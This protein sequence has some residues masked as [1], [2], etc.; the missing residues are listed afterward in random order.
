MFEED[1]RIGIAHRSREQTNHIERSRRRNYLQPGYHHAPVLDALAVLRAETC[2]A[3]IRGAYNQRTLHLA[4]RHVAALGK[5]IRE[6]IETDGN[7]VR[8]H[9]LS[10]GL[11]PSHRRAHSRA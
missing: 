7:E 2:P 4:V 11:E 6:V 10:D 8:E 9:D 5:L 1:H 3:A